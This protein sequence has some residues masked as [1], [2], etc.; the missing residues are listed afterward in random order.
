MRLLHT[1][2]LHIG[3]SRY[4]T[5][6]TTS[7][8][9]DFIATFRR[10]AEV[11]IAEKVD[12][13][14][15]PG[16]VTNTRR[17]APRELVGFAEPVSEL[18]LANIL[19]LVS[20][21]NHDGPDQ[22][23]NP[24]TNALAWVHPLRLP[25][26]K[27]ITEPFTGLITTPSGAAFNLVA[28]PYPHK[29][30]FDHLLPDLSPDERT[31]AISKKLEDGIDAMVDKARADHP[32]H[33]LIFMGHLSTVGAALGT[34]VSMRFGW[35]VTVRTGIL[36]RVDYGALGHI[37]RQQQVG[38]H[39]WYAGSPDYIDFGEEGQTKG[40]L[41]VEVEQRKS[42]KVEV[43]DSHARRLRTI[44]MHRTNDGWKARPDDDV[45]GQ[46]IRLRIVVAPDD[47]VAPSEVA[48]ISAGFRAKGAT[49][50]KTEVLLPEKEEQQRQALTHQVDPIEALRTW[51][52][53]GGHE[54]EPA[55][56]AGVELIN[57]TGVE[58]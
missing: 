3:L 56:S 47:E 29:R 41:L 12:A 40:F 27:M 49:F 31:E 10:F 11:A 4:S 1:A 53:S 8:I 16:D 39:S 17:P 52:I 42:P 54:V 44:E 43:I 33:P 9:D 46:V 21:G 34:E 38:E 45:R 26:V 37:H 28:V 5:P 2:D 13:V 22:P 20:S 19:T 25:N 30:A 6:G 36:D 24:D 48:A 58:S 35:D 7:R 50:V 51:L 32:E 15:I 14:L 55:L 18:T 23:G 57:S